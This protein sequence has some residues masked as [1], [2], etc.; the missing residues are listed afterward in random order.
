M[1]TEWGWLVAIY[2]FLGGLGAGAFLVA[3]VFELSG[4][5][6][7]FEFCPITL[8][9]AILPGPLV[10]IGTILLIFDLGAGLREPLRILHMYSNPNSV[11]TWG[12]W[13]L[14]AFIP[15]ALAYGVL[16]LVDTF[17][18]KGKEKAILASTP[19]ALPSDAPTE[20]DQVVATVLEGDKIPA[21]DS[22]QVS[23]ETPETEKKPAKRFPV[24]TLKR[25]VAAVGSVFAVVT[26]LYTGVL[27][28]AAGPAIPFWSI[29]LIPSTAIP[30]MPFLF[31]VSAISTGMSLT[32][33]LSGSLAESEIQKK[34]RQLPVIH[35]VLIL[36]EAALIALMLI[37]ASGQGGSAALSA[38]ALISGGNSLVFWIL[39]VLPGLVIPLVV[40][41][42]RRVGVH[43][44]P[45][46]LI[47]GILILVA[48]LVLRY[49]VLASGIPVVL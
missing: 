25:I 24:R 17:G 28:S 12:I 30:A 18:N 43:W 45:L 3:A 41:V 35:L 20:I 32:V 39:F 21:V 10:A 38:Q 11:M 5:R 14:T 9:G 44:R 47:E 40:I 27:I 37:S 49:L 34:I 2:L 36:L 22:L 13:I 6:D 16:E 7:E 1:Q 4:K 23:E 29:P 42:L 19:I 31:L 8:V 33:L 26:A 15:L 46:E 48:G